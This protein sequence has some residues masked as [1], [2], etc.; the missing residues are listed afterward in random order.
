M[1]SGPGE[2]RTPD[3]LLRKQGIDLLASPHVT[4][5]SQNSSNYAEKT[6]LELKMKTAGNPSFQGDKRVGGA[7]FE[8]ATTGV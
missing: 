5:V 3:P 6:V 7:G 4:A 2:T 8:P 1:R